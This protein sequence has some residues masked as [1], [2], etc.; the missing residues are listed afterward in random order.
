MAEKLF[1]FCVLR[2]AYNTEVYEKY[3]CIGEVY[4]KVGV[5]LHQLFICTLRFFCFNSIFHR[6]DW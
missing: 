5:S 3:K 2:V 1:P 6:F 4:K